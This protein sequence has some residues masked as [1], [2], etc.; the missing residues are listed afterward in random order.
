MIAKQPV[1]GVP[2]PEYHPAHADDKVPDEPEQ[3]VQQKRDYDE[4]NNYRQHAKDLTPLLVMCQPMM[5]VGEAAAKP[6]AH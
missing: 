4:S 1:D 3:K 2:D 5:L 6:V